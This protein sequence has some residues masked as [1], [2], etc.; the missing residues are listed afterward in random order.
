VCGT[1]SYRLVYDILQRANSDSSSGG[2]TEQFVACTACAKKLVYFEEIYLSVIFGEG[3]K[4]I[5]EDSTWW[6]QIS[7]DLM[8]KAIYQWLDR[9]SLV[10]RAIG[11]HH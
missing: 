2:P 6:E 1:V 9:I 4:D 5:S 11:G 10:I 3:Y 8:N 7:Q